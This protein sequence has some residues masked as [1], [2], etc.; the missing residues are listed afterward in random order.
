VL[1]QKPTPTTTITSTHVSTWPMQATELKPALQ[2]VLAIARA[3]MGVLLLH[4]EAGGTMGKLDGRTGV[5]RIVLRPKIEF[6]GEAPDPE[7]LAQLHHEAHERCFIANSLKSE[8]VV[9][10]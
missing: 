3:D 7:S 4:D 9:E 6:E 8:V 10:G 1:L 5:A 2:L